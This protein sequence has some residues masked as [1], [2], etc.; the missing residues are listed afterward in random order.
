MK[1]D[2]SH[3]LLKI[4]DTQAE[5]MAAQRLR[6]RV[7]VEEMG[8]EVCEAQHQAKLEQDAFDPFFDHLI[9]IDTSIVDPMESVVAAYRLMRRSVAA[10][11]I[12][13]YG[14]SEYEL[15]GMLQ[16]S[17]DSVELGRSCVAA[18]HRG[19]VALRLMWNGVATYVERHGIEVLFGVASFPG[20]DPAPYAQ[21]LSLLEASYQALPQFGVV[22]H[23]DRALEMNMLPARKIDRLV[24]MKQIPPLIKAYLRLGGG[25]ARHAVIDHQFRTIDVC[26][27]MDTAAMSPKHKAQFLGLP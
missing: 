11:N 18:S 3:L 13:F 17:R 6:Y 9:L 12:G 21:A 10:Q 4:A 14:Q 27:I 7:F 5:I 23:P 2:T 22:A 1:F 15:S 16:H 8:A 20:I 19:G 26:M 24:A 25:V